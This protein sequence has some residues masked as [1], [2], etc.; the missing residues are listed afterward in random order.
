MSDLNFPAIHAAYTDYKTKYK[1]G[2]TSAIPQP[3]ANGPIHNM[4]L[5]AMAMTPNKDGETHGTMVIRALTEHLKRVTPDVNALHKGATA[6]Q[7]NPPRL[8][9]NT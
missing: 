8:M 7:A 4:V 5:H 9:N 2:G 6:E 3:V 1:G